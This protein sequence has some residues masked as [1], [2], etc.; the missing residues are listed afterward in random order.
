[1]GTFPFV[2][3]G[4]CIGL[5]LV[6]IVAVFFWKRNKEG[7]AKGTGYRV[8]F[9][10]GI[11]FLTLGIIYEIVFFASGKTVFLVLGITFIGMGLSYLAISLGNRDK[12]KSNRMD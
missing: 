4:I 8:L 11:T 12:W 7:K 9:I 10:L 5:I 6:G 2:L 3:I 1:M